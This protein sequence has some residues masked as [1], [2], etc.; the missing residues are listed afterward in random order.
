MEIWQPDLWSKSDFNKVCITNVVFS[1]TDIL[2]KCDFLFT[3]IPVGATLIVIMMIIEFTNYF[4]WSYTAMHPIFFSQ[5]I[6]SYYPSSDHPILY[7]T[8]LSTI[9]DRSK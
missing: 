8:I 6:I 7:Y 5:H 4:S 2:F 1:F 3:D 9:Y